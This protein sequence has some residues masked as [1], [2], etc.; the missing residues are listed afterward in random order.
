VSSKKNIP[1]SP[2]D[3]VFTG[4]GSYPIQLL[5]E[6]S[7]EI[8]RARLKD[9]FYSVLKDFSPLTSQIRINQEGRYEFYP[10]EGS[11]GYRE[12]PIENIE[13]DNPQSVLSIFEPVETFPG[14]VLTKV[15]VG[16][17]KEKTYLAVA[18]SHAIVDGYS[19]FYF[20]CSWASAFKRTAYL[21]PSH[22]RQVLIPELKSQ[23]LS[24]TDFLNKVG[25]FWNK[26]RPGLS[27]QKLTWK[28][29]EYSRSELSE[30]KRK[31]MAES[32]QPFTDNDVLVGRLSLELGSSTS[33]EMYVSCP[34][35]FRRLHP[36]LTKN[37]FGNAVRCCVFAL[38]FGSSAVSIVD[39]AQRTRM[40]VNA[41][42]LPSIESSL[43][44][45]EQLRQANGVGIYEELHVV[46][47]HNGL[48]VTNLS[49]APLEQ[50]DFGT[51]P[52]TAIR[53][54]TPAPRVAMVVAVKDGLGILYNSPVE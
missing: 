5:F 36:K 34:V 42:D 19:F 30:L 45:L 20:L 43:E 51:G 8:D 16:F 18:I 37:Y 49:R 4:S 31:A 13:L 29:W 54:A 17:S 14:Q 33:S 6:F 22:D 32:H 10:V 46:H 52:T 15:T 40:G 7:G 50:I 21:P 2:I 28:Q 26:K 24:R 39:V 38:K 53:S 44:G 11:V 27:E 9:S 12:V 25:L 47:P 48:L 3:H 23:L 41:V 1:L 35:D